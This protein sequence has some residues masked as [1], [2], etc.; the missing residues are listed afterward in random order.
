MMSLGYLYISISDES[1]TGKEIEG[2]HRKNKRQ[3]RPYPNPPS[4]DGHTPMLEQ[5]S[6]IDRDGIG[7]SK[8]IRKW[9][10]QRKPWLTALSPTHFPMTRAKDTESA[11]KPQHTEPGTEGIELFLSGISKKTLIM[12]K[13]WWKGTWCTQGVCVHN[14]CTIL[15]PHM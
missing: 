1:Q 14:L 4:V 8:S 15:S 2:W 10:A 3:H 9:K 13:L 5:S 12:G 6:A 11:C 7:R